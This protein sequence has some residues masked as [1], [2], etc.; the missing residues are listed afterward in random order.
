MGI[1][2]RLFGKYTI[3]EGKSI[4]EEWTSEQVR[5]K[6]EYYR[7]MS[8]EKVE[9]EIRT[10]IRAL[11]S[12]DKEEALKS[13]VDMA[14][15]R[16]IFGFRIIETLEKIGV[17]LENLEEI[18]VDMFFCPN[19][20]KAVASSPCPNCGEN[21]LKKLNEPYAR[22]VPENL[23]QADIDRMWDQK[24]EGSA[25]RAYLAGKLIFAEKE[26][27]RRRECERLGIKWRKD[28][29]EIIREK[30]VVIPLI[31]ILNDSEIDWDIKEKAAEIHG[32]IKDSRAV[33]SL[34]SLLNSDYWS[35]AS[36]AAEA[37]GEIGDKRAVDALISILK[38]ENWGRDFEGKMW[39]Y[40]SPVRKKAAEALGKIGD[41]KAI[42]PLTEVAQNDKDSGVRKAAEEALQKYKK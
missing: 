38:K 6:E 11:D 27:A 22:D 30:R 1:L 23:T 2:D 13:I 35:P 28:R 4:R 7:Q 16:H 10:L 42:R 3:K 36:A 37:L 41:K 29:N 15:A 8:E 14:R 20:K 32:K 39:D 5:K 9:E 19:C 18:E 31:A 26:L 25:Q 24:V 21:S 40:A 12:K 34:I 17:G 33:D